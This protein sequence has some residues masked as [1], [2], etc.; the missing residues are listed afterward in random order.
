M[1]TKYNKGAQMARLQ[2]RVDAKAELMAQY[3]EARDHRSSYEEDS[4]EFI[5]YNDEMRD[6]QAMIKSL[7]LEMPNKRYTSKHIL[8]KF[9]K[10]M[11]RNEFMRERVNPLASA[12]FGG[13]R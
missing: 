7:K 13:G 3:F 10:A 5:K 8:S 12:I 4:V 2:A 9:R 11:E 1:P 6:I